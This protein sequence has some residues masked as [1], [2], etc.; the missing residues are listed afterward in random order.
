[1][2]LAITF[3]GLDLL[4][5]NLTTDSPSPEPDETEAYDCLSTPIGFTSRGL[6]VNVLN[7]NDPPDTPGWTPE[8]RPWDA[9][10]CCERCTEVCEPP[11]NVVLGEN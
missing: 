3:L 9:T 1:M 5:V 6:G 10:T 4:T 11:P 2:Q 8:S 7:P